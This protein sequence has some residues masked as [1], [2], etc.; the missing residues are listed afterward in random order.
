MF[1]AVARRGHDHA[2]KSENNLRTRV[3][4]PIHDAPEVARVAT[5]DQ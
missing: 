3:P 2:I 4:L 5:I 1:V